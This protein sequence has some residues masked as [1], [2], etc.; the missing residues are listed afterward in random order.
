MARTFITSHLDYCNIILYGP[1]KNHINK[2]Q[3]LQNTTFHLV[4]NS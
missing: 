4:T 1:H 2:L 3:A